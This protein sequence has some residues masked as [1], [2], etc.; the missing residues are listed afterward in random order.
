[1]TLVLSRRKGIANWLIGGFSMGIVSGELSYD[2]RTWP[3][4]GLAE[5]IM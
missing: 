1:M 3:V 2:G 5:L 4:H